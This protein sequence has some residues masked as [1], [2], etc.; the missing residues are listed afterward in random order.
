MNDSSPQPHYC[1]TAAY[2]L[3]AQQVQDL[4]AEGA[5]LRAAIAIAMHEMPELDYRVIEDQITEISNE[6]LSR[7]HSDNPRALVSHAHQVLFEE[8]GFQGNQENYYDPGNSYIPQVLA[9]RRGIP[10]TLALVY[11]E[12]LERIGMSVTGINAPGHFL[13]SVW[14]DGR[15]MIVDAFSGGRVMSRADAYDRIEALLGHID[16]RQDLLKPA[17][18]HGW[19]ARILQNLQVV[20]GQS[21]QQNS[22]AAMLE[23]SELLTNDE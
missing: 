17:T 4:E 6:I 18:S 9:T 2:D 21:R 16:R 3:F 5:L 19:L 15:P 7:V 12:V 11:K 8:Q 13:A 10:I 23:L 20:F 14:L 22:L 1:S